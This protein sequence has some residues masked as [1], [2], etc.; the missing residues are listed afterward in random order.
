LLKWNSPGCEH[1]V[2]ATSHSL[3]E[4]LAKVSGLKQF[5]GLVA[6]LGLSGVDLPLP[7]GEPFSISPLLEADRQGMPW[8]LEKLNQT[9]LKAGA[10]FAREQRPWRAK[11]PR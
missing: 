9:K 2:I 11:C 4:S 5:R 3:A 8:L 6:E 7:L 1:G 10:G